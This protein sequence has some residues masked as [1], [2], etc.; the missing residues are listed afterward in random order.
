MNKVYFD[1]EYIETSWTFL[2][3]DKMYYFLDNFYEIFKI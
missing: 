1:K 3:N 2:I